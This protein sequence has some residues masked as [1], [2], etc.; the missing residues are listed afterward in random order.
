M[1]VQLTVEQVKELLVIAQQRGTVDSWIRLAVEWMEE[2][3]R[4]ATDMKEQLNKQN[5]TLENSSAERLQEKVVCPVC[6]GAGKLYNS[7]MPYPCPDCNSWYKGN[8]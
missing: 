2:A 4:Q 3:S 8:T 7:N 1:K 5:T 6:D